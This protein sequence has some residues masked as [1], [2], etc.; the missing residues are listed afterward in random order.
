MNIETFFRLTV[1]ATLAT[2]VGISGYFRRKADQETNE[3]ISRKVDGNALMNIIRL[4]GLALWLSPLV[5]AFN[6]A[7][8]NWSKLDLPEGLRWLGAGLGL[9]SVF[10][11]YWLFSNIGNNITA[12]SATRKEHK[13]VTRG[14]YRWIRHPLYT[15][16]LMLF[17]ALGLMADNWFIMMLGGLTFLVMVLRTPKEEAG[18][19]EKFGDEY[20]NYMKTTG[21]F[22]PKLF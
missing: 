19:I 10:G 2:S 14:P 4:G 18:L 17:V 6:P 15:F 12:T 7:W 21:A 16:G 9:L 20:L 3:T 22:L 8:M 1:F 5:Y 11:V 13:L